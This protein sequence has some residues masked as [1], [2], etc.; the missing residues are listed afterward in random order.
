[1]PTSSCVISLPHDTKLVFGNMS[2]LEP[3]HRRN[4]APDAV[5]SGIHLP[6]ASHLSLARMDNGT[7]TYR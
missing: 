4:N 2:Q 5:Q 3:Y 7:D 1:M 6:S